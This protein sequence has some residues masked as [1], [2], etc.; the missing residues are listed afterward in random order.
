[1]TDRVPARGRARGR[2]RHPDEYQEFTVRRPAQGLEQQM[3]HLQVH[4]YNPKSTDGARGGGGEIRGDR[5]GG[6]QHKGGR[7]RGRVGSDDDKKGHLDGSSG[8]GRDQARAVGQ[9]RRGKMAKT[10]NPLQQMSESK[11]TVVWTKP[12]NI[13]NKRGNTGQPIILLS[14]YYEVMSRPDWAL[15]MYHVDF[16]PVEERTRVKKQLLRQHT[17]ALGNYIFDGNL[18]YMAR[19]LEKDPLQLA[20]KR[21]DDNTVYAVKIRFIKEIP[22]SDT[23]FLQLSRPYV[24]YCI[25]FCSKSLTLRKKTL[26]FLINTIWTR[27][28]RP[29]TWKKADIQLIPEPKDKRILH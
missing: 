4:E 3:F 20:S 2:Q 1:M 6:A 14:N 9:A 24:N 7:A 16:I 26:F 5:G 10:F 29:G 15:C 12:Q 17:Q 13:T 28:I 19:K 21:P 23:Q 18:L 27:R 8:C 11:E 25:L 22:A